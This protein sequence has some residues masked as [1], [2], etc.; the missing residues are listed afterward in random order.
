MASLKTHNKELIVSNLS[1]FK[2]ITEVQTIL[3]EQ[4]GLE[5]PLTSII[6]YNPDNSPKLAKKWRHQFSDTRQKYI[7][8]IATVPIANKGFRL[9]EMQR[10]YLYLRNE[11][12]ILGAQSILE[13]AAKEVGGDFV[14]S[15]QGRTPTGETVFQQVNNYFLKMRSK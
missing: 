9:R 6:Y 2:T 4:E 12:N 8:E 7:D 14:G 5:V 11:G 15:E 10:N 3:R 1:M 13:Q